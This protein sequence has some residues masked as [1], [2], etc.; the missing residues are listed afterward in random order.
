[1]SD[2]T[3]PSQ[4]SESGSPPRRKSGV[5]WWILGGVA[6]STL[7]GC[8]GIFAVLL[9]LGFA[10]PETSVYTGNRIPKEYMQTMK[11]VGAVGNGEK[12]QFFYSDAMTD[13]RDGF[14]FVS[15]LKVLVYAQGEGNE[16]MQAIPFDQIEN[17]EI[18]RNDSFFQDS[19]ITLYL[20]DDEIISFPVSSEFDRDQKFFDAIQS[21][22]GSSPVDD[23]EE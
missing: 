11:E 3:T 22:I 21:R 18:Y 10:T 7:L 9:Y 19:E 4:F 6:V 20:Q 8:G 23:Y 17:A 5:V 2:L 13:I 14:Y 1:M 16:P 12:V 15:N